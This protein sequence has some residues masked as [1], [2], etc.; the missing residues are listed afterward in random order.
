[1]RDVDRGHG[2]LLDGRERLHGRE[3]KNICIRGGRRRAGGGVHVGPAAFGAGQTNGGSS[4]LGGVARHGT[5]RLVPAP[6]PRRVDGAGAAQ[7]RVT[8]GCVQKTPTARG[9]VHTRAPPRATAADP[10]RFPSSGARPGLQTRRH[11]ATPTTHVR[12]R[13]LAEPLWTCGWRSVHGLSVPADTQGQCRGGI[14]NTEGNAAAA[15]GLGVHHRMS[16]A[17]A[18]RGHRKR[19][20]H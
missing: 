16:G 7:R 18:R 19:T 5:A 8:H 12:A 2:L 10:S 15:S 1:M 6:S 9:G 20:L 11:G 4:K 13:A 3:K 17:A 14:W